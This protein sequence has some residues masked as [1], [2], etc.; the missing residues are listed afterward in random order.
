VPQHEAAVL[1]AQLRAIDVLKDLKACMQG[2]GYAIGRPVVRN[3]SR[4]RAFFGFDRAP[5]SPVAPTARKRFS[6]AHHT[7]EARVRM[8]PRIDAI[9][10]ADRAPL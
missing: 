5:T 10:K 9:V 1:D 7:C 3:L 6:R 8:A 4:G 2:Y